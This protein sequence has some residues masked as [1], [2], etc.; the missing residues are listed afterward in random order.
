MTNLRGKHKQIYNL[1]VKEVDPQVNWA[2]LVEEKLV[3]PRLQLGRGRVCGENPPLNVTTVTREVVTSPMFSDVCV[4]EE[5]EAQ[6]GAVPRPE[7]HSRGD[8]E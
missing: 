4:H 7:S 8:E 6:R 1:A 5:S 2:A 3:R